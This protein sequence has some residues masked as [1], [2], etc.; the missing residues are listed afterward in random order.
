MNESVAAIY[1]RRGGWKLVGKDGRREG[2]KRDALYPEQQLGC[3]A[4]RPGATQCLHSHQPPSQNQKERKK[5]NQP[6]VSVTK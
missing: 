3:L 1:E 2:K 6:E 5:K 4:F